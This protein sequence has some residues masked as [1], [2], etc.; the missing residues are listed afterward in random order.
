VAGMAL[1]TLTVGSALVFASVVVRRRLPVLEGTP[2]AVA[3][4]LMATLGFYAIHLVP[5]A[6]SLLGKPGVAVSALALL[7]V[8]RLVPAVPRAEPEPAFLPGPPSGRTSWVIAGSAAALLVVYVLAH[9]LDHGREAVASVDMTTFHLPNVAHWIQGGSFWQD[10]EFVPYR[11]FGTYPNTSDVF[12]LGAIL[13]FD[14]DF[15]I[16]FVGIPFLA[17]TWV[18]IY[19]LARELTAPAALAVLF[20]SCFVAMPVVNFPA[21]EA[22]ADAPMLAA[23][24]SGVL[25]LMRFRRTGARADLVLAGVGLGLSFGMKWYAP[26]AV[27]V[28]ISAW[29]GA[30]F[31]ERKGARATLLTTAGLTGIVLAVGGFWLLRNLVEVGNPVFPIEVSLGDLTILDAPRDIHRERIGYSLA[32]Y[33]DE[34]GIWRDIFWPSFLA[35]MSYVAVLLWA[36]LPLAGVIAWLGRR[37]P[38][39]ATER[40]RSVLLCLAMAAGIAVLYIFIPYTAFGLEGQP[41]QA[42]ANARYVVPALV[43]AAALGAWA[44]GRLGRA[45]LFLEVVALG[46]LLDGLNKSGAK[47]V[48]VSTKAVLAAALVVSALAGAVWVLRRRGPVR[49]RS[50]PILVAGGCAALLVLAGLHLQEE[51]F[52]DYRY[53]LVEPTAGWVRDHAPSGRRIGV[54]GEGFV[55]YQMFG[56]RL[57]ND[58]GY[59]GPV[60]DGLLRPHTRS[61]DF[62]A[63]LKRNGYH[64]VLIQHNDVMAPG[65]PQRQERWLRSLGYRLVASGRAPEAGGQLK[66][67]YTAPSGAF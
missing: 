57:E 56:P 49:W 32:H 41:V 55:V 38:G 3:F 52:N 48:D 20:A 35:F 23:F 29:A 60:E 18:A 46:V 67:L 58:V 33:L 31:L 8:T 7:A 40:T 5:G 21:F 19:A 27:A 12:T 9:L 1:L 30:A 14:N 15:L 26:V 2:R 62:A 34:P 6:M 51:R 10:T 45:R 61:K 11:S 54:A 17:L 66:T 63:A 16:R 36:V 44:A 13:P 25:F 64:L 42:A 53:A 24:A 65:L 4:G 39:A 59:V 43:L 50:T 47:N 37:Q 28:V 22:L